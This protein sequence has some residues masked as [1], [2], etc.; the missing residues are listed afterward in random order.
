ME[1]ELGLLPSID[2][3]IYVLTSLV[4]RFIFKLPDYIYISVIVIAIIMMVIGAV[5]NRKFNDTK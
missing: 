5:Q 1:K 3:S 2:I 4:D